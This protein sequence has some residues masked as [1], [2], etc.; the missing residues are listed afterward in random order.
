MIMGTPLGNAAGIVG[1]R[2][3]RD[4][5]AP[6]MGAR[7]QVDVIA[8]DVEGISLLLENGF[9]VTGRV[10]VE[11]QSS[12][13]ASNVSGMRIQ[14]QSDPVIPPLSIPPVNPE[15]D[16]S[17]SIAGVTPGSYRVSV[18]GLPRG[19]YLKTARLAGED[20]LNGGLRVDGSANGP[21]E[22]VLGNTPG[23]VDATVLDDRQMPIA[24]VTVALVPQGAQERRYDIYRSATSDASGRIRL[25]SVVPGEY[26]IYA[27][28]SVE[29][30]AW[31][32]PDFMRSYPNDGTS[33]RIS[34]GGSATV[35]VRLIPYR[36][37]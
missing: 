10:G 19:T 12:N 34:E 32:D 16:G 28:E 9:N 18:T 3:G 1:G 29:N 20:V 14:L 22:I 7:A 36:L 30:G 23:T 27:W 11:G 2:G 25:E 17:F 15:A 5:N 13:S 31:T 8:A 33:V 35:D 4:P 6:V 26:R 37:N 24:A 21:L